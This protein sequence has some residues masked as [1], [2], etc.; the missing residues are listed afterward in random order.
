MNKILLGVATVALFTI[1]TA[2]AALITLSEA[3]LDT[4]SYSSGT[5]VTG[6]FETPG[7]LPGINLAA[8]WGSDG[9]GAGEFCTAANPCESIWQIDLGS[10]LSIGATDEFGLTFENNNGTTWEF[11]YTLSDMNS[12]VIGSA[13]GDIA[14]TNPNSFSTFYVAGALEIRYVDIFV[15]S[16]GSTDTKDSSP[17][18]NVRA[19]PEPLTLSL[20][21]LGL[22]GVAG[23]G[24][25]KKKA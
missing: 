16:T 15:K 12:N 3:E 13:S 20:M 5:N 4:A 24:R 19:V 18:F 21:G 14:A 6:N 17:D 8:I 7:A 1:G 22:L 23:M 9:L 25:L 11:G 10:D 2:Q